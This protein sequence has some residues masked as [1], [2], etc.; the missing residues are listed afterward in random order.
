MGIYLHHKV[1]TR[2][3]KNMKDWTKEV[4]EYKEKIK[5]MSE[6]EAYKFLW[7]EYFFKHN[8]SK[9]A[10]DWLIKWL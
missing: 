8:L 3:T 6:E 1:K 10:H 9:R 2:R 7:D 4:E 5:D